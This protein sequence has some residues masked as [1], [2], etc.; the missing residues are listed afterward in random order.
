MQFDQMT[1]NVQFAAVRQTRQVTTGHPNKLRM[2]GEPQDLHSGCAVTL[3]KVDE[4]R[5]GWIESDTFV[6]TLGARRLLPLLHTIPRLS[7]FTRL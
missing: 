1:Y 3:A 6:R 2:E 5:L 4:W 7:A